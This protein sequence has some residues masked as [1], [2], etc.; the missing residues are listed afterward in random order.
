M[1]SAGS[2][3]IDAETGPNFKAYFRYYGPD[4]NLYYLST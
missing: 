3:F 4:F 2:A 1:N